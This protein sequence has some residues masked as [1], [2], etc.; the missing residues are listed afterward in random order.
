MIHEFQYWYVGE[1]E[2]VESPK[3]WH[4]DWF[5]EYVWTLSEEMKGPIPATLTRMS[6]AKHMDINAYCM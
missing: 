2:H 5:M 3:G 4:E 6:H 1:K